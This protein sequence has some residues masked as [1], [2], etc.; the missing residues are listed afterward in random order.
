MVTFQVFGIAQPKGSSRAFLPKGHT[1]PIVTSDNPRLKDWESAVRSAA[2][3]FAETHFIDGPVALDLAFYL[4]KPKS[5]PKKRTHCITR[6]DT[7]KLIRS[8]EDALIGVL[9]KDDAAVVEIRATKAY[10][11]VGSAAKAVI[12]VRSAAP[13]IAS[14]DQQLLL[15]AS[16]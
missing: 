6:P 5:A 13:A 3:L 4:P 11:P 9:F 1:R 2:Q 10:A 14:E 8:T 7:S 16:A 12:T 15:G